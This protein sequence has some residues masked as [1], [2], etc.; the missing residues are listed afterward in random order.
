LQVEKY[1]MPLYKATG[2]LWVA[3]DLKDFVS[4]SYSAG[5]SSSRSSRVRGKKSQTAEDSGVSEAGEGKRSRPAWGVVAISNRERERERET[6]EAA[7][8]AKQALSV[9]VS[10]SL[11]QQQGLPQQ[12]QQ[13]LPQQ[14]QQ[15]LPPSVS[16]AGPTPV[17]DPSIAVP[18]SVPVLPIPS[19]PGTVTGARGEGDFSVPVGVSSK[20]RKLDDGG[21][22]AM[23]PDTQSRDEGQGQGLMGEK[24]AGGAGTSTGLGPGV[25]MGEGGFAMPT[26][27][28]V[29]SKRV[30]LSLGGR[31]EKDLSV[32]KESEKDKDKERESGGAFERRL[33]YED[34][35][36]H[37]TLGLDLSLG[38][39]HKFVGHRYDHDL[40][41]QVSRR[42]MEGWLVETEALREGNQGGAWS[43]MEWDALV[44]RR[45]CCLSVMA[46]ECVCVC[47]WVSNHCMVSP[48]TN[49]TLLYSLSPAPQ[50]ST[51]RT[52]ILN[53][54]A[55]HYIEWS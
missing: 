34:S 23:D 21:H 47:V 43:G 31:K 45:Q 42:G 36:R 30:S 53:S 54:H 24:K 51:A 10:L 26:G 55:V 3:L 49:S 50:H 6:T 41:T 35:V 15:G 11:Q 4:D 2:R 7:A 44:K 40:Y 20:R 12:Q 48:T 39:I 52:L 5:S 1:K 37:T 46:V 38:H 29:S 17:P 33:L 25:G 19:G 27:L 8:S 14:Q 32:E 9:A 16:L 28:G 18:V 22:V 13:G